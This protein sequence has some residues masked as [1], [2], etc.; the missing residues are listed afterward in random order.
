MGATQP[1]LELAQHSADGRGGLV[2]LSRRAAAA[3]LGGVR[4]RV[5]RQLRAR[6]PEP[7]RGLLALHPRALC[8]VHLRQ[9]SGRRALA[10]RSPVRGVRRRG[11]GA[12]DPARAVQA[13]DRRGA[14]RR[15]A[16]A[17]LRAAAR[18]LGRVAGGGDQRVG[19]AD[20]DLGRRR[21]GAS[22]PRSRSACCWRSAAAP[23]C[24]CCAAPAS[25]SS[26]CGAACR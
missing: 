20:A 7:R 21:R 9:L 26:S 4:C 24:G 13:L 3:R 6:L 17:G 2:P 1:V 16:A 15:P 19:R 18:R 23:R 25:P 8:A 12:A 22:R 10:R 5:A 14:R 11:R